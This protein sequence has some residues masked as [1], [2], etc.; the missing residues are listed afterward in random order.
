MT[1]VKSSLQLA[2]YQL[3]S[4]ERPV[5]LLVLLF[6]MVPWFALIAGV[7][8]DFWKLGGFFFLHLLVMSLIIRDRR[9]YRS[10]GLTRAGAVQRELVLS[11]PALLLVGL[12]TLPNLGTTGW[13]WVVPMG[14][15]ALVTDIAIT[16]WMMNPERRGDG[17]G[18]T[19]WF[20]PARSGSMSRR[21]LVVPML[22]WTVPGG[23]LL[24]LVLGFGDPHQGTLLWSL[25]M[26]V[27]LLGLFLTPAL[28]VQTGA[29]SLA[30][31]QTLGL[32]RRAWVRVVTPVA[33]L[34]PV[35]GLVVAWLA[36]VVLDLWGVGAGDIIQ[37]FAVAAPGLAAL[38]A[39][40]S[41][42]VVSLGA[43]GSVLGAGFIGGSGPLIMIPSMNLLD[44]P[45]P[46]PVIV[47]VVAGGF[48]LLIALHVQHRL[49][50]AVNGARIT[51]PARRPADSYS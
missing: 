8:N 25:L 4:M 11:V 17:A 16:L 26:A 6:V 22:R 49:I 47:A 31:W 38:F 2:G 50:N 14:I 46:T 37:R 23:L 36:L 32:P 35:L 44:E 15:V 5:L 18:N 24:G 10:L 34:A 45:A 41:L 51:P 7:T 21:L 30:T 28:E 12:I 27:G 19:T 48:F 43:T 9:V 42:L 20:G 1:A 33:V 39:G 3:R 13:I 29:A 40:M